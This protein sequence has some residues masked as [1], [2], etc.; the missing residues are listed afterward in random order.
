MRAVF[1][2]ILGM[3]LTGSLVILAVLAVRLGL[4]RAPKIYSYLLWAVV[5]LRLLTPFGIPM[6]VPMPD[7]RLP[8]LFG[9]ES[10]AA[11]YMS[12]NRM[13]RA[14]RASIFGV[15]IFFWP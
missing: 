14:A 4:K 5:L 10:G 13:P 3:S 1:S 7:V 2:A 11:E 15:S 9:A 8:G 12:V 6:E